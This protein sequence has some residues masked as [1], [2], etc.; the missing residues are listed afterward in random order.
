MKIL[1][2]LVVLITLNFNLYAQVG[3]GTISPDASAILD[4]E[5]GDKGFLPPRLSTQERNDIAQPAVGLTV[6][7]T[8]ENCLQW[9]IGGNA[10]HNACGGNT[11]LEYPDGTTFCDSEI[12]EIVEVTSVATGGRIWM[13]RNLG[14]SQVANA[15]EDAD[16][17]GDIYQWGRAAEGHQCRSS[18]IFDTFEANTPVPNANNDWD[19]LFITSFN[20]WL[21]TNI[22]ALWQGVNGENNPCP[23]GFRLPT[24]AEWEN[25]FDSWTPKDASGAFDS[26]LKLTTGGNRN[27]NDGD[28]INEDIEGSYWS[29]TSSGTE[30]A[31]R[32]EFTT[33][34]DARMD[35][36][37]RS[38][39][40]SIRC[41]KE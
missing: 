38:T 33:T 35:D 32:L 40:A 21:D 28:I 10:W 31:F 13:D 2:V 8:T 24:R 27:R 20:N 5:S 16:A 37:P 12:T 14:A 25:E 30:R 1:K 29:S 15:I 3:I 23:N 6:Y 19:G 7:N 18:S 41:I 11:Y 39:G 4:V 34:S 36:D 26:N 9:Y 22:T 17:Y